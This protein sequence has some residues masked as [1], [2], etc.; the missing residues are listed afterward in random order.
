VG[1]DGRARSAEAL[2]VFFH[3]AV[4]LVGPQT[5][6]EIGAFEAAASRR[7]KAEHPAC[8]VLAFEASPQVHA[9]HSS[10]TDYTAAGV[11]YRN[12]AVADHDGS[13]ELHVGGAAVAGNA[14]SLLDRV[15][16]PDASTVT[17]PSVTLDGAVGDDPG[18]TVLWIDVEGAV[19]QV[20]AAGGRALRH[21]DLA[22]VEV[23]DGEHWKGQA[24]AVDVI[25]TMLGV[26]LYP[27]LR[28]VEYAG[29]YNIVFASDRLLRDLA[30]T[31]ALEV[32]LHDQA[33]RHEPSA[34]RSNDTVR[35]VAR[36]LRRA[37]RR[38]TDIRKP[39]ARR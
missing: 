10:R 18:R 7:V 6:A 34:L 17:V 2:N 32:A 28:D 39:D 15:D 25:E 22:K 9:F 14:A 12:L 8:T 21:V 24:L 31:K 33:T 20:L 11:D 26:D 19:G 16:T 5:F 36:P 1:L 38:L 35:Q 13:I 30:F 37:A 4:A 29:Q 27:V 3:A 23:E